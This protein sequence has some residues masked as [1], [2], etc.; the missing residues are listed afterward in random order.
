MDPVKFGHDE[1]IY[2]YQPSI[3]NAPHGPP[4]KKPFE[5]DTPD[6]TGKAKKDKDSRKEKGEKGEKGKSHLQN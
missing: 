5:I 2:I 1:A 3:A 4:P 6:K